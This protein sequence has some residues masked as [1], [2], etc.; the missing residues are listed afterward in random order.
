[1]NAATMTLRSG[2]SGYFADNFD[3]TNWAHVTSTTNIATNG[4]VLKVIY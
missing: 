1:M 2:T 3:G 4:D